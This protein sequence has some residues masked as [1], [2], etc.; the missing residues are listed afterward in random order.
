[1]IKFL[2]EYKK[3]TIN[4]GQNMHTLSVFKGIKN[5]EKNVCKKRNPIH[6]CNVLFNNN[7]FR[8]LVCL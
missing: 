3:P 5:E 1:M 2:N 7:F 8:G 4:S 6:S